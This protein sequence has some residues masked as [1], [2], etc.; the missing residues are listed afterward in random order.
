VRSGLE[1]ADCLSRRPT[2]LRE[3]APDDTR[4]LTL[5]PLDREQIE[6]LIGSLG[7]LPAEDWSEAFVSLVAESSKGSPLLVLETIRA[8]VEDGLLTR[9]QDRWSCSDAPRLVARLEAGHFMKS[10]VRSLGDTERAL[11]LVVATSG[12]PLSE[13][14]AVKALAVDLAAY[15]S[16]K[17]SLESRGLVKSADGTLAE[18][19]MKS[20]LLQLPA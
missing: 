14:I 16:A 11:L 7:T 20:P 17:M 18:R 19:T 3:N 8:C 1:A 6:Q 9:E 15:E 13:S 12:L 2:E 5:R 10:R 4:T